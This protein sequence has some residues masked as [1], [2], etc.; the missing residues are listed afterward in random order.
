MCVLCCV[1]VLSHV[2][3]CN[4][5]DCSPPGSLVHG[6]LQAIILEWVAISSSRG[7]SQ[8]RGQ[9]CIF[10]VSCIGRFFNTKPLGKPYHRLADIS[11]WVIFLGFLSYSIDLYVCLCVSTILFWLLELCGIFRQS[12]SF[13]SVLSQDCFGYSGSFVFPYKFSNNLF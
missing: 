8:L 1:V 10:C 9:T 4:P 7:S 5:M 11:A 3:L 12:D 13:N 6:I 2:W